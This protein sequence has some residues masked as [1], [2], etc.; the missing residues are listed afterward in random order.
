MTF[1]IDI[2]RAGRTWRIAYPFA[3]LRARGAL[4]G[5][6]GYDLGAH[7]L[8]EARQA[9]VSAAALLPLAMPG[10]WMVNAR[11]TSRAFRRWLSPPLDATFCELVERLDRAAWDAQPEDAR[12]AVVELVAALVDGAARDG[13][14]LAAVSKVLALVCPTVCPLLDDAAIWYAHDAIDCP[15]SADAPAAGV[16]HLLPMLD[17]FARS[18]DRGRGPLTLLSSRYALASLDAAQVL[19]RLVWFESWGYRHSHAAPGTRWWWLVDGD[20]EGIVPV[21]P[22]HPDAGETAPHAQL[23]LA[24]APASEW[25]DRARA[26]LAAG[27]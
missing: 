11:A 10:S 14:S 1:E 2:D 20:R 12:A 27:Y 26:A 19:D 21:D 15:D 9:G 24:S 8:R 23:D 25:V 6:Y 7:A 5:A 17:W 18:V 22:P 3:K 4:P 16:E 13:G